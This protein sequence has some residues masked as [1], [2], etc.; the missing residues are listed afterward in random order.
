ML[1]EHPCVY[2]Y[3]LMRTTSPAA[4]MGVSFH[5]HTLAFLHLLS[6][7]VHSLL[8]LPASFL[9]ISA[10]WASLP[11]ASSWPPDSNLGHE[12]FCLGMTTDA[13]RLFLW[14]LPCCCLACGR[15]CSNH[16]CVI[17]AA[18]QHSGGGAKAK[19]TGPCSGK[20]LFPA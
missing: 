19:P 5:F 15:D 2:E 20:C 9:P 1:W 16:W 8:V 14:G 10:H 4:S 3:E 13:L 18:G 6:S 7:R 12:D 11:P 17:H